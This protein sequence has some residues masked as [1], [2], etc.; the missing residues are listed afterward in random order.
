[1][2]LLTWCT[3][4]DKNL[5]AKNLIRCLTSF[6]PVFLLTFLS[7][8]SYGANSAVILLHE[9]E[10]KAN[11]LVDPKKQHAYPNIIRLP[12]VEF[13]L[14]WVQKDI[15]SSIDSRILESIV[16]RDANGTEMIRW[17]L[18]PTADDLMS[19]GMKNRARAEFIDKYNKEIIDFVTQRGGDPTLHYYYT[20]YP[21]ASTTF[22]VEDPNSHIVFYVKTSTGLPPVGS[23]S[24]P[25]KP[26]LAW[27]ARDARTIS[28]YLI[29]L[30]K[31]IGFEHFGF[32]EE[33][34]GFTIGELDRALIIRDAA[35]MKNL[36]SEFYYV[37]GFAITDEAV[38]KMIA[39]KNGFSNPEE[40]WSLHAPKI[41]A[42]AFS[43]LFLK[44]GLRLD[45]PHGQ[46]FLFELD[47]N[48][49]LTGRLIFRDLAD[50]VIHPYY[51][52]LYARKYKLEHIEKL[53]IVSDEMFTV[54][55]ILETTSYTPMAN[56]LIN[57]AW[58]PKQ[59][60]LIGKWQKSYVLESEKYFQELTD[61][62]VEQLDSSTERKYPGSKYRVM[63]NSM[64]AYSFNMNTEDPLWQEFLSRIQNRSRLRAE[65]RCESLFSSHP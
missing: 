19:A 18:A 1:M 32:L 21:S 34:A 40:F 27:E 43:E 44:T 41:L 20:G 45:S 51:F 7:T 55:R 65:K 15:S 13:P 38:G 53:K 17:V 11:P 2:T 26:R 29:G 54:V 35:D 6:L 62:T 8:N 12:H 49:K 33:P 42:R 23:F 50:M 24:N 47:K 46:N 10:T 57:H 48:M 64:V 37:P 22:E 59:E 9:L 14:S 25:S 63:Q 16:F 28:E 30:Q 4:A 3:F 61:L 58:L 56:S 31:E 39:E 5:L 36:T 60:I 52:M